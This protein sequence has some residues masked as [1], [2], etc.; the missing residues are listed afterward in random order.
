M[1]DCQVPLQNAPSLRVIIALLIVSGVTPALAE[2]TVRFFVRAFIPKVHPTNPGAIKPIPGNSS[3]FMIPDVLPT[4][5][6]FD[7]DHRDFSDDP[8]AS[9][10]LATDI[11]L[12]VG[13]SVEVRPSAGTFH[14]AGPTVRRM[15]VNGSGEKT[16]V[17]S[18]GAC[19]VG[20]PAVT[21]SQ[22]QLV[23]GC[24]AGNPLVPGAPRIDYVGTITYDRTGRTLAFQ[25]TVGSFPAFESYASLNGGPFRRIFAVAPAPGSTPWALF[26]AG[27]GFQSRPLAKVPVKLE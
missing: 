14:R 2:D 7:T 19:S 26:D 27:L 12:V 10:R 16:A 25:A 8:R 21:S 24:S 18:V 4:G 6:C 13:K 15:C 22:V 20:E 3:R 17:A 9:A 1:N 5:Y 23:L 11:T